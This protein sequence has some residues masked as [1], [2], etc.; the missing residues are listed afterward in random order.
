M[1]LNKGVS[2]IVPLYNKKEFIA[3][4]IDSIL[5]QSFK[6]FEL[7]IV[8][9]GSTDGSMDIV[10]R[11]TDPRIKLIRQENQGP[12]AARNTGANLAS[13]EFL[14]FLDAD[15]AWHKDYLTKG[16]KLLD[17]AGDKV[18]AVCSGYFEYPKGNSTEE[19]WRRRGIKQGIIN[20]LP[21]TP[22]TFVINALAYMSCW[23]TIIRKEVFK[24]LGGFYALRRCTYGEDAY[25]WLKVLFSKKVLFNTDPLVNYH[26]DASELSSS[27]ALKSRGIEPF[28]LRPGPIKAYC[29]KELLPLF[30]EVIRIRSMKTACVLALAGH[31]RKAKILL[32]RKKLSRLDKLIFYLLKVIFTKPLYEYYQV[33]LS[34]IKGRSKYDIYN[35]NL[36]QNLGA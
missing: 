30:D 18:A 14:A 27:S 16:V 2:V 5:S 19:M 25:F 20:V 4:A 17:A 35:T 15:D 33:L 11:Y 36:T 28:I 34:K 31:W 7:I 24:E 26:R 8:D 6:N 1:T 23:S 3:R 12:G 10:R 29:P 9:D 13:G 21:E 22:P 32:K